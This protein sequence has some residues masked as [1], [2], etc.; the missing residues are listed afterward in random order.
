[1]TIDQIKIKILE[2]VNVDYTMSDI[3]DFICRLIKKTGTK[4]SDI[5]SIAEM[6]NNVT[7]IYIEKLEMSP[8]DME[9]EIGSLEGQVEELGKLKDEID[10]KLSE[11]QN[12]IVKLEKENEELDS[13]NK[14]LKYDIDQLREEL[15]ELKDHWEDMNLENKFNDCE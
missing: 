4:E 15:K 8:E 6:I 9:E 14:S 13:K 7:T 12:I 1:M 3:P 11:A 2:H 10:E 5:K